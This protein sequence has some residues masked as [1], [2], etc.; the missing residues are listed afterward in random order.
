M[1]TIPR[2]QTPKQR[3]YQKACRES[4]PNGA[5]L[6]MVDQKS[7]IPPV[8]SRSSNGTPLYRKVCACGAVSIVDKR[9]LGKPC[10]PC[11]NRARSTHGL[12]ARGRTDPLYQLL[13]NMEAR[14]RY[15][16]VTYY[17]YYG[18]RGITVCREWLDDP[19]AFVAWATANN[20]KQGMEIDR[21]DPD[22][23]YCP[24]NCRIVTHQENSQR[25][26]R[27][28]TRPDQVQRVRASF[29]AGL[30]VK[31]AARAAGV[32]YMVAWHIKKSPGVWSNV[33]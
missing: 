4:H 20:W 32:S 16:S 26:R 8:H 11:A 23:N 6:L 29:R 25:T 14:C 22:G 15:P 31:A 1:N 17:R 19:R 21:I 12:A 5:A 27:I 30:S 13:K 9:K 3:A 10:L 33:P 28:H 2:G 18:G 24:E 7:N